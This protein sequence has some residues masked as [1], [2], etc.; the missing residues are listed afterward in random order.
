MSGN[1]S[2][3]ILS[4][5]EKIL[6]PHRSLCVLVSLAS[7]QVCHRAPQIQIFTY[8]TFDSGFN[9]ANSSDYFDCH[10]HCAAKDW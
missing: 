3:D 1:G 4:V 7:S 9:F 5:S 8:L 10:L 6:N 2:G